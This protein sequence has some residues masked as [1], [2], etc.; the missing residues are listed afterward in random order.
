M[1]L[2][3]IS[4]LTKPLPARRAVK[5]YVEELSIAIIKE[6][7][8]RET[9]RDGQIFYVCNNLS[10]FEKI[11]LNLLKIFPDLKIAMIH[12]QMSSKLVS[13]Q[14]QNFYDKNIT[15]LFVQL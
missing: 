11:K 3:D 9:M 13:E 14:I 8:H 10:S 7:I 6:A 15:Y 12:G 5:V 1:G 4:Y 2:K